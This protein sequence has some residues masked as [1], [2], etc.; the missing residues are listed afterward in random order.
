MPHAPQSPGQLAHV[1]PLSH[2][3]SPQSAPQLPQSAAHV[4]HDSLASQV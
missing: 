2:E 3:A 1:S 4:V